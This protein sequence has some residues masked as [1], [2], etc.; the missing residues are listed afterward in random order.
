MLK[1]GG[2]LGDEDEAEAEVHGTREWNDLWGG[3]EAW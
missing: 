1:R 2:C 3:S